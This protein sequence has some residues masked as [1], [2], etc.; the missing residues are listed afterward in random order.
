MD[1]QAEVVFPS[2]GEMTQPVVPRFALLMYHLSRVPWI[3]MQLS[4]GIFMA[5]IAIALT[6]FD[7]GIWA[8]LAFIGSGLA[9]LGGIVTLMV[10][11]LREARQQAIPA[12]EER[13]LQV[14]RQ[15]RCPH[16]TAIFERLAESTKTLESSIREK[17]W[18]Y[19][20]KAY[21]EHARQAALLFKQHRLKEAFRE[22]C[23][24][25][26]VLMETVHLYR[27]KSDD[28]KPVWD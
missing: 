2:S 8:I 26:L 7:F 5:L 6:P 17:N 18:E 14:Y 27:G 21:Q 12:P 13:T 23:R 20:G 4:F 1:S 16:D 19:D 28:F 25:M 15:T 11:G 10:Q 22:Q 3:F 9:L 24:A